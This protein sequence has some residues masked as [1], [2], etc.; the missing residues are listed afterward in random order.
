MFSLGVPMFLMGDEVRRTQHGNNNAYCQDNELSWF[1]W[2]D[3]ERHA[4]VR[5]FFALLCKQRSQRSMYVENQ[6][7]SLVDML[8]E[9]Q[10]AWHGVKLNEPDWGEDSHAVAFGGMLKRQGLIFHLILNAYWEPLQFELPNSNNNPWRRWIDTSLDSPEDISP[11]NEAPEWNQQ[12]YR[13]ADR[14]VVMLYKHCEGS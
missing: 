11:W 1:D 4:D 7:V 14:S 12:S 9:A 5:R 8:R 2:D 10:K 6:R 3:L 13:V